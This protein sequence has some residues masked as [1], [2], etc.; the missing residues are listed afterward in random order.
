MSTPMRCPPVVLLFCGICVVVQLL[1][2]PEL[3]L[4]LPIGREDVFIADLLHRYL[5]LRTVAVQQLHL[6]QAVTYAFIH[7][8]WWHLGINLFSIWLTGSS[9]EKI[10]GW[11][12]AS[13]LLLLSALSGALGFLL[14]VWLDPRLSPHLIC[15]GASA[16]LT[17]LIGTITTLFTRERITLYLLF[18]PLRIPVRL[19]FPF[20]L[21][22]LVAEATFLK[23][24]TA[25]GAHLGGWFA[26]LLYG[27]VLRKTFP[28]RRENDPEQTR[29]T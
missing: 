14:S 8:S 7:G 22:L 10:I 4:P 25:Y 19:L 1:L 9:L 18:L 16:V 29:I 28:T 24:N 13:P 27:Y 3:R 17:A 15:L 11:R 21:I 12:K 26:G 6:Y 23:F 5:P 2:L 20:M